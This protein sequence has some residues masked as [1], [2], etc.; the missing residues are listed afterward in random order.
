MVGTQA[1][2]RLPPQMLRRIKRIYNLLGRI[3]KRIYNLLMVTWDEANLRKH[4]FDFAGCEG[5]FHGF[6][7]TREDRS[8]GYGEPRFQ[9]LGMWNGILVFVVHT[10]RPEGDHIISIRKA[11]SHEQRTYWSHFPG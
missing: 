7:M 1:L 9:T 6:T 10:P 3:L 8:E 2:H 11:D 4:G 5:V